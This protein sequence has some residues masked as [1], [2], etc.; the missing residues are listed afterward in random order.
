MCVA[1]TAMVC[2]PAAHGLGAQF[3]EDTPGA[4]VS[5]S[6]VASGD[7]VTVSANVCDVGATVNFFLDGS[8]VGSGITDADGSAVATVVIAGAPGT[9]SISNS[10]NTSVLSVT[11][12]DEDSGGSLPRTGSDPTTT[13]AADDAE[14]HSSSGRNLGILAAAAG[15]ALLGVGAALIYRAGRRRGSVG[16][17][18][19]DF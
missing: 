18:P 19:Q 7:T 10:C 17:G 8:T 3:P 14:A 9:H 4:S 11:I 2:C 12:A 6:T 15:V 13:V 16:S 1:I 5:D